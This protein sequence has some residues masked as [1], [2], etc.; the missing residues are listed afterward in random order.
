MA[1]TKIRK[2]TTLQQEQWWNVFEIEEGSLSLVNN[3]SLVIVLGQMQDSSI[4]SKLQTMR[5]SHWKDN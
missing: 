5:Q 1:F 2:T 3:T 4:T